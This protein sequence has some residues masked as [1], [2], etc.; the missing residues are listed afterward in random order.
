MYLFMTGTDKKKSILLYQLFS[1]NELYKLNLVLL[2]SEKKKND[3]NV[4]KNY[5]IIL[6]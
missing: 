5:L 4:K 2:I 1:A 6:I 3:E